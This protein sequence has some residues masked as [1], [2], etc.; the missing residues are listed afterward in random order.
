MKEQVLRSP[1]VDK[2]FL[3]LANQ[4]IDPSEVKIE[5]STP[6][7]PPRTK[8]NFTSPNPILSFFRMNWP[9]TPIPNKNPAK[10]NERSDCRRL[11]VKQWPQSTQPSG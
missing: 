8:P 7:N 1:F 4:V 3:D 10:T 11:P 6:I 5:N 2:R 9:I